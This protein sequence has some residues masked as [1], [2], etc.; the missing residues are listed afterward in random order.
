MKEKILYKL[1][2]LEPSF[3]SIHDFSDKHKGHESVKGKAGETHFNII[4]VSEMFTNLTKIQRHKI[5][6]NALS[7][8][9]KE[10]IHALT[11]KAYNNIEYKD[12][13]GKNSKK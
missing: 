4:I 6:H 5:I 1:S 3:I 10:K 9:L 7:V 12:Y 8:E 13:L 11:I 2:V